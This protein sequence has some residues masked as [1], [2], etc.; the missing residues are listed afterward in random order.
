MYYTNEELLNMGIR[1]GNNV[2]IHKTVLFFG[3][4]NISIGSNT[5]IDAFSILSAKE[6][7]EIGSFVHIACGCYVFGSN[8][9]ILED[10]TGISAHCSVYTSNDDYKNGYLTGP[11]LPAEYRK[12]REGKV[13]LQKYSLVG[14]SSVLLPGVVLGEGAAV[15]ALT[16]VN[17]SVEEYDI[18]SG[19]P[20]TVVGKRDRER[21]HE[22]AY[23]HS[24]KG[25]P[26]V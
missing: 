22:L 26:S 18:V 7:I 12:V 11:M 1:V 10:Y 21:L 15:G 24:R 23:R 20:M 3:A 5:R 19:N 17:R 2:R 4:E 16:L 6:E 9:V 25:H 14:A 8:G 13:I